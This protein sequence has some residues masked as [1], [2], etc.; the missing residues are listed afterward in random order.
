MADNVNPDNKMS[1]KTKGLI[2]LAVLSVVAVI[3]LVV[4]IALA[5][6]N[7]SRSRDAKSESTTVEEVA[8]RESAGNTEEE[9]SDGAD[10]KQTTEDS[11]T[12]EDESKKLEEENRKKLEENTTA[13]Y[14]AYLAEIENNYEDYSCVTTGYFWGE[15]NPDREEKT[16]AIGDF[17]GDEVPEMIAV[18]RSSTVSSEWWSANVF[19][20]S[21]DPDKG[22]IVKWDLN[23]SEEG[24]G[25]LWTQMNGG[26]GPSFPINRVFTKSD[27]KGVIFYIFQ[28][29]ETGEDGFSF[30]ET[31]VSVDDDGSI[32]PVINSLA[33]LAHL[34]YSN[35]P[36]YKISGNVVSYEEFKKK[37]DE[38]LS[39]YNT[40]LLT[41]YDSISSFRGNTPEPEAISASQLLDGQSLSAQSYIV[42]DAVTFLKKAL[43]QDTAENTTE[44]TTATQAS[45][46]ETPPTAIGEFETVRGCVC[47]IPAGFENVTSD[48]TVVHY[49]YDFYNPDLDME[50]HLIDTMK[51]NIPMSL[52]EMY[53]DYMN[54]PT[55]TY[56][57]FYDDWYVVSGYDGAGNVFYVKDRVINRGSGDEYYS[58][59]I[60]YPDDAEKPICDEIVGEF[61][62]TFV[63]PE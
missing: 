8:S 46:E 4:V 22:E 3:L 58:I 48:S 32:K 60:K 51:D 6:R 28:Q 20:W 23:G 21:F 37:T 61:I 34:N 26:V 53:T 52:R 17:W 44:E 39:P 38:M 18:K 5:I 62:Q 63:Y 35:P 50:I 42:A 36:E 40:V 9:N 25:L 15:V 24:E 33:A 57:G 30:Y 2:V 12:T 55:V 1:G 14:K 43:G 7:L 45:T 56:E 13:A 29:D 27:G 47:Y 16:V 49:A 10:D 11:Q 54:A 59:S 31:L 41:S 19:I